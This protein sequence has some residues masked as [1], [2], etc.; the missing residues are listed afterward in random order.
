MQI[1]RTQGQPWAFLLFVN[2]SPSLRH[3]RDPL[4]HLRGSCLSVWLGLAHWYCV[5]NFGHS[6]TI[7]RCVSEL[8]LALFISDAFRNFH[9]SPTAWIFLQLSKLTP[10]IPHWRSGFS[11]SPVPPKGAMNQTHNDIDYMKY[12]HYHY[13]S[14]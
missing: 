14:N 5:R 8:S 6:L 10:G 3:S 12:N 1:K 2:R 13:H 11:G 4:R 7:V 9:L